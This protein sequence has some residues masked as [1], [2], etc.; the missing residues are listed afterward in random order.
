MSVLDSFMAIPQFLKEKLD[1]LGTGLEQYFPPAP[2]TPHISAPPPP[3]KM[4][5]Q[6][7]V[8]KF[9]SG[10]ITQDEANRLLNSGQEPTTPSPS[11]SAMP[12]PGGTISPELLSK[13][14]N[15][16]SNPTPPIS[17]YAPQL[18][19]AGQNLPDPLLPAVMSLMETGGM[20]HMASGNNPFNIGPGIS[21]PSPDVAILGGGPN[22]QQGLAGILKSG[23]YNDYIKSGNLEDFFKHFTPP[24][25]DN[26]SMEELLNRYMTLRSLFEGK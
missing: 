21:Y 2:P 3:P 9:H 14:F 15:Q 1:Q 16:F 4:S 24:G 11:P 5:D 8:D 7:I 26:P 13:G 10:Q 23:I 18:A 19:Q 17:A 25:G 12:S 22:N 6:E 20:Q